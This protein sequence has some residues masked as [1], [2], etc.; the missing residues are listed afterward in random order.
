MLYYTPPTTHH[1]PVVLVFS[2][3]LC[4]LAWTLR[5]MVYCEHQRNEVDLPED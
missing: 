1:R 3:G 4:Q 2:S 5:T